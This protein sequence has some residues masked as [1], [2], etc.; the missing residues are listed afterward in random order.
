MGIIP[1]PKLCLEQKRG[2][3]NIVA[4]GHLVRGSTHLIGAP[5]CFALSVTKIRLD[6]LNLCFRTGTCRLVAT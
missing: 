5:L 4:G 2:I 6:K 1:W 3:K